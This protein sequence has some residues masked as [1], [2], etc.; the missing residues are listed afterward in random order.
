MRADPGQVAADMMTIGRGGV[1]TKRVTEASSTMAIA[2]GAFTGAVGAVADKQ[3][4]IFPALESFW[5]FLESFS[6]CTRGSLVVSRTDSENVFVRSELLYGHLRTN[7]VRNGYARDARTRSE[8]SL[9]RSSWF[10]PHLIGC[11]VCG[12]IGVDFRHPNRGDGTRARS[13]PA[14]KTFVN[15]IFMWNTMKFWN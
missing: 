14:E 2:T 7:Y 4:A 9:R 1:S 15:P 13:R 5:W 12:V 11:P 6:S 3:T 8:L 10:K